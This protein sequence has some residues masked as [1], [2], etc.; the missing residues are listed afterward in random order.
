MVSQQVRGLKLP[1]WDLGVCLFSDSNLAAGF[2]MFQLALIYLVVI[3]RQ[4]N[5]LVSP[6]WVVHTPIVTMIDGLKCF[7]V[8]SSQ[9]PQ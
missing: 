6:C 3:L 4:I 1:I 7:F 9:I 8:S 2:T 5:L